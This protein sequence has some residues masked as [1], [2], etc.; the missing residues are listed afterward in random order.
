ML[1]IDRPNGDVVP[2]KALPEPY[3]EIVQTLQ[4]PDGLSFRWRQ[5]RSTEQGMAYI[6]VTPEGAGVMRFEFYGEP[7]GD[8]DTLGAAAVLADWNGEAMHS[9]MARADVQGETFAGGGKLHRVQMEIERPP[10]WW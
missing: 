1:A 6:H 9:F 4:G 2:L 8:G 7:L 10:E 3:D 5:F